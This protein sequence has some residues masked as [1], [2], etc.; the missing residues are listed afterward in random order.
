MNEKAGYFDSRGYPR[1]EGA[2]SESGPSHSSH[3]SS[4]PPRRPHLTIAP[5]K[6]A[7]IEPPSSSAFA[8]PSPRA[9]NFGDAP[10][11]PK[12]TN[13]RDSQMW[14]R[15]SMMMHSQQLQEKKDSEKEC[16]TVDRK[17]VV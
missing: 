13:Q 10:R 12:P 2:Y 5:P 7:F 3:R 15:F 1:S 8:P 11:T 14:S 4:S 17:S 16:V 6:A 9:V